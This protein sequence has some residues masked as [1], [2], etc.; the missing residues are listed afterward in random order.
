MSHTCKLA[1]CSSRLIQRVTVQ[2][3]PD[4][5]NPFGYK[6]KLQQGRTVAA[7]THGTH[8]RTCEKSRVKK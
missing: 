2:L 5:L 8:V 7:C 3:N 4:F 6:E 1:T